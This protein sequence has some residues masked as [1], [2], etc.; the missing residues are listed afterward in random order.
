MKYG[1]DKN[2][3]FILLLLVKK[4]KLKKMFQHILIVKLVQKESLNY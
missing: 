2:N 4:M 1:G 3:V